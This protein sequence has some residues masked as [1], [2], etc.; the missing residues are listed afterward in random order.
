MFTTACCLVEGLELG[1]SLELNLVSS[2]LVVKHM[3]LYY[4]LLY[5]QYKLQFC[6]L[7]LVGVRHKHGN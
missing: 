6:T 5:K 7:I 2:W 4:F 1:L 3:Y